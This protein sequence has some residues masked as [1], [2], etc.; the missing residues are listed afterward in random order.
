M[1]RN[2]LRQVARPL[3][4]GRIHSLSKH[5]QV[6]R[7]PG[8]GGKKMF[9]STVNQQARQ[10]EPI[11][12]SVREYVAK[13][14]VDG[15]ET[16]GG[17]LIGRPEALELLREAVCKGEHAGDLCLSLCCVFQGHLPG[18]LGL[19]D[20]PLG[21]EELGIDGIL[22]GTDSSGRRQAL[23]LDR[24]V[25]LCPHRYYLLM[26]GSGLSRLLGHLAFTV[27]QRLHAGLHAS[28]KDVK[29]VG[30]MSRLLLPLQGGRTGSFHCLAMFLLPA[31]K[32]V[33]VLQ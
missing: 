14:K 21:I 23:C 2:A 11:L 18:A 12:T 19:P 28:R 1:L 13:A 24:H 25:G 8:E 22:D 10:R 30:P 17:L 29:L 6:L 4:R 15:A 32:L 5:H 20:L 33:K 9:R 26:H 31:L 16:L 3:Q 27:V 7:Q